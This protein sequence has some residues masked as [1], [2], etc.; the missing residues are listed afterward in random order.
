MK[1]ILQDIE[2]LCATRAH[3][4]EAWFAERYEDAPPPFY[5]STDLRYSGLKLAPVDTN[6]FP[7]G[8]NNLSE[9]A[10]ELAAKRFA[11]RLVRDYPDAKKIL[12]LPEHHTRNQGYIHNLS[13]L[14]TLLEEAGAEVKIGRMD[15]EAVTLETDSG[16]AL[17]STPIER[18]GNY[19]ATKDGYQ[20][21]LLVVNNDLTA[22]APEIL[23]SL[24]QPI[25]PP[26]GL[27]WYRRKKSVYFNAYD[28]QVRAFSEAFD[29]DGWR[30]RT[31]SHQCG[32]I[33]FK[34]RKG[35]E[36]VAIGVEKVIHKLQEKYKQYDIKDDPYVFIKADS[37]TYGMGIMTVRSGEE[38]YEM[39]KKSRNK[40]NVIKEGSVN[41]EVIIQEGVPTIDTKGEGI[42]EPVIYMV[43][44]KSVGGAWRVHEGRDAYKNLNAQGMHFAPMKDEMIES[45]AD[46][47]PA[48]IKAQ[49][50]VAELASL[51]A[52]HEAYDTPHPCDEK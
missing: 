22:G 51:A 28:E 10:K 34:E 32:K 3:D 27:G 15:E 21:D 49:K 4:I 42:A 37:G 33:N 7:A 13:V 20:P 44:G 16:I 48:H 43:D 5:S 31:I 11:E 6:L 50:L 8:F 24:E 12:I 18:K 23:C 14:K 47:A 35:I 36:C 25:I 38:V 46:A 40:M 17:A 9:R 41:T 2:A 26:T 19:V 45:Y 52:A 30:L 29:I 1:D 39:N